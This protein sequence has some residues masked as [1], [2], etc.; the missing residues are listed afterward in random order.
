MA[1]PISRFG[2]NNVRVR[3]I[4]PLMVKDAVKRGRAS[5]FTTHFSENLRV[6]DT[7]CMYS[8]IGVLGSIRLRLRDVSV[9][10]PIDPT[11]TCDSR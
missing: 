2:F 5:L 7:T 4:A 3:Q 8:D 9:H 10:T 6:F 11:G 1:M